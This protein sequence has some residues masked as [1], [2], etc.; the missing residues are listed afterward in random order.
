[1]KKIII[2]IIFI[3]TI[4]IG[5][6]F[7][8]QPLKNQISFLTVK[9]TNLTEL[10]VG[11]LELGLK[12]RNYSE[13]EWIKTSNSNYFKVNNRKEIVAISLENNQS[14]KN[15]TINIIQL[16]KIFMIIL[17]KMP[18]IEWMIRVIKL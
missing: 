1:M 9:N 8:I 4:I 17:V 5:L 18:I 10:K 13:N 3:I 7:F 14:Y 15:R 2:F 6:L 11:Q 12:K 16:K